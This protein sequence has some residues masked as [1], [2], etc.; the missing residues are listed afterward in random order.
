MPK[1]LETMLAKRAFENALEAYW[2][3]GHHDQDF[4]LLEDIQ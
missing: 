2:D 4:T 1:P 3:T